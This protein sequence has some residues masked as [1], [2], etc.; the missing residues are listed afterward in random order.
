MPL[1][2]TPSFLRRVILICGCDQVFLDFERNSGSLHV[3][4]GQFSR[5][6][7]VFY[8]YK[9]FFAFFILIIIR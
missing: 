8:V 4:D 3:E 2:G 9:R 7:A 6:V 5:I 1:R